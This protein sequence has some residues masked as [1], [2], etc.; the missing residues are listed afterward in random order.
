MNEREKERQRER[1]RERERE[2]VTRKPHHIHIYEICIT[3]GQSLR[4]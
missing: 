3:L 1:E 4:K 2:R